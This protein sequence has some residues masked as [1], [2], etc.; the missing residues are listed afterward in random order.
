[1]DFLLDTRNSEHHVSCPKVI[2]SNL[3]VC[4]DGANIDDTVVQT[5]QT[6]QNC[7]RTGV[8]ATGIIAHA[9]KGSSLNWSELESLQLNRKP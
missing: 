8:A 3:S 1:M 7:K 5:Q 4:V 9:H 2:G 6:V